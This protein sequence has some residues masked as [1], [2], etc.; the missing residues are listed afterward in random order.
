MNSET[1]VPDV[2]S[3]GFLN[4]CSYWRLTCLYQGVH[5]YMYVRIERDRGIGR[6]YHGCKSQ[7]DA[8][9]L[10]NYSKMESTDLATQY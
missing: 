7:T 10:M 1:L 8:F 6:Y 3:R 5:A 4:S 2:V 9:T